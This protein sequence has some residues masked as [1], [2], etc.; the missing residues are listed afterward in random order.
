MSNQHRRNGGEFFSSI[1]SHTWGARNFLFH[2]YKPLEMGRLSENY[3][4]SFLYGISWNC[5]QNLEKKM[6]RKNRS[7]H[8][9]WIQ[10]GITTIINTHIVNS[11]RKRKTEIFCGI[12]GV[13]HS[14]F[15][16]IK[17]STKL[18]LMDFFS[19]SFLQS[20]I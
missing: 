9:I 13:I 8:I 19:G 7:W 12:K 10:V 11:I 16:F 5:I 3:A 6:G 2:S 20:T 17:S 1:L 14:I 15:F 4:R 18:F